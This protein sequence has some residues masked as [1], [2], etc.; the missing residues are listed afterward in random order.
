M[1][2]S[3]P[4]IALTL[5][6]LTSVADPNPY[7]PAACTGTVV[8]VS[9]FVMSAFADP[10]SDVDGCAE[11]AD[12][13]GLEVE[14]AD[15]SIVPLADE[16]MYVAHVLQP[17]FPTC[18]TIQTSGAI[19]MTGHSQ[20]TSVPI[21][22]YYP[23]GANLLVDSADWFWAAPL[24]DVP[25]GSE[26]TTPACFADPDP[27][28]GGALDSSGAIRGCSINTPPR[29]TDS[30]GLNVF[31]SQVAIHG[32]VAGRYRGTLYTKDTGITTGDIFVGQVLLVVGGTGDFEYATGRIAVAG[33]ELGGGP[34]GA[35]Y[36]GHIC[37][38]PPPE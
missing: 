2:R 9:G 5:F 25:G 21:F 33:Q 15:H 17:Y 22:G 23:A 4:S 10:V 6:A 28:S 37:L 31:T 11:A 27:A 12:L 18:L 3:T 26:A 7:S 38:N 36:T 35:F 29:P 1:T 24:V 8:P 34:P 32:S 30:A 16:V 13:G 20:L 14:L 19:R